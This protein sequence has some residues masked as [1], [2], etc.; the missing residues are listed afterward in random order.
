[1]TDETLTAS[2]TEFVRDVEPRLRISLCAALGSD[3]GR[4]CTA[5]ALAYAWENWGRLSTMDNPAG[6]LYRVGRSRARRYRNRRPILPPVPSDRMPWVEPRLPS[7][8]GRLS[9]RQRV[10]VVLLHGLDWTYPEVADLLSL[11]V[12]SVQKHAERGL[13]KLARAL[14]A[15]L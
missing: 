4:E 3:V 9:E 7:A 15:P 1:L 13:A 12:S 5:E 11:S 8:V 2:F 14:G 6:Y 10:V